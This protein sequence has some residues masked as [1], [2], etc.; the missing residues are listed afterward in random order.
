MKRMILG[1]ALALGGLVVAAQP[2]TAGFR[3]SSYSYSY[4]TT[5]EVCRVTCVYCLDMAGNEVSL[6]CSETCWERNL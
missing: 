3:C 2:A 1:F 5:W 4:V 6:Y